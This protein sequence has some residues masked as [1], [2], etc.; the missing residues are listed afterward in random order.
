MFATFEKTMALHPNWK[1]PAPLPAMPAPSDPTQRLIWT[2]SDQAAA[3]RPWLP[4]VAEQDDAWWATF[5][6]ALERQH[7]GRE[8]SRAMAGR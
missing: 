8:H 2:V 4:T 1:H 5:G 7:A 6:E 3:A